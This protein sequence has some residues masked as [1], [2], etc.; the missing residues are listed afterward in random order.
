LSCRRMQVSSRGRPTL[1]LNNYKRNQERED[2]GVGAKTSGAFRS[3]QKGG[4]AAEEVP[5]QR[6]A[7]KRLISLGGVEISLRTERVKR[8]GNRGREMKYHVRGD[9][10]S[11]PYVR[12]AKATLLGRKKVRKKGDQWT[13]SS[14]GEEKS[15]RMPERWWRKGG[16]QRKSYYLYQDKHTWARGEGED[17]QSHSSQ[18]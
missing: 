12:G 4:K 18:R 9:D 7:K 13:K 1:W 5:L 14:K 15:R 11:S 3:Y 17:N 10:S 6:Q 2:I 16:R 8:R